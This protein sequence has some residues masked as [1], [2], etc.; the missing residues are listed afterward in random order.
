MSRHHLPSTISARQ[1]S[2]SLAQANKIHQT[3]LGTT[4]CAKECGV[5]SIGHGEGSESV[6]PLRVLLITRVLF[7]WGVVRLTDPDGK[8]FIRQQRMS[9]I[10]ALT[11]QDCKSILELTNTFAH[12]GYSLM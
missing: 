12:L 4:H 2:T 3:H 11:L 9:L 8:K 10:R 5:A 7:E 1:R 6:D